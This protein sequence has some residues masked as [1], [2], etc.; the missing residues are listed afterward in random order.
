MNSY[1][2]TMV[3]AAKGNLT[4]NVKLVKRISKRKTEVVKEWS[5]KTVQEMNEIIA[6]RPTQELSVKCSQG[7]YV[8]ETPNGGRVLSCD[9]TYEVTIYE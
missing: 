9:T 6:N 2:T 4:V 7:N 8:Y 3:N 1:I 5:V